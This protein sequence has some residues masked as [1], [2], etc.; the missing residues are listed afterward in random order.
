MVRSKLASSG[1]L[2][3]QPNIALASDTPAHKT[4]FSPG[5]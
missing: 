4:M 1:T 2:G 5:P 3:S